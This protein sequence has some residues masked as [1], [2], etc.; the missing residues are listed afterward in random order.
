[1]THSGDPKSCRIEITVFL[2]LE[3]NVGNTIEL[4]WPRARSSVINAL[5]LQLPQEVSV[6]KK[7]KKK[8][9]FFVFYWQ[10]IFFLTALFFFMQIHFFFLL[11][12]KNHP[13]KKKYSCGKEKIVLPLSRKHFLGTRK[14]FWLWKRF[15]EQLKVIKFQCETTCDLSKQFSIP[16]RDPQDYHDNNVDSWKNRASPNDKEKET[17]RRKKSN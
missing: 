4:T 6:A 14:N 8:K 9:F 3:I 7:V 16:V 13:A 10:S 15:I 11:Q 2:F 17:D 5:I 12:G 1:V